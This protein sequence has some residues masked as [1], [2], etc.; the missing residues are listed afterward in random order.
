MLLQGTGEW[1]RK[2]ASGNHAIAS[3][4][5]S[6]SNT[7]ARPPPITCDTG[8]PNHH[9]IIEVWNW[10]KEYNRERWW[11][12]LENRQEQFPRLPAQLPRLPAQLPLLQNNG[13]GNWR[14]MSEPA[15]AR[16]TNHPESQTARDQNSTP[17]FARECHSTS[18]WRSASQTFP[19]PTV[20]EGKVWT[21]PQFC[22]RFE[23]WSTWT[24]LLE[25][26]QLDNH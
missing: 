23:N 24:G 7:P 3:F 10:G 18:F 8:K 1:T 2:F 19:F 9:Y 5:T 6:P 16:W 20:A 15:W 14:N 13:K 17:E 25:G 11:R 21:K 12:W 26:M 4:V 22:S